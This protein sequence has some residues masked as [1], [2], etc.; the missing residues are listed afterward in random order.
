MLPP[1]KIALVGVVVSIVFKEILY[2]WTK[3]IGIRSKSSALIAN[4][5]HHRSDAISS[6]P[7]LIAV[8]VASINPNLA[9]I[10]NIGALVVSIFILKVSWDII[11]P[12]IS[13]LA[14]RSA[15][16]KD[17]E[18]ISSIASGIN[19]VKSVHAIRTRKLGYCLHVD[20]H[21]LVDGD[22]TVKMGHD[23]SE[24]VKHELL[25]KGPEVLDVVV[26]L[27]PYMNI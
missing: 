21:V 1:G 27:E 9:F 23:I 10:D 8:A 13:E 15:S 14:D 11:N 2:H 12:A 22:M 16:K 24:V 26:H 3:A 25:E 19:G 5:W 4:A 7:A 6:I 17:L 20:L 18:K